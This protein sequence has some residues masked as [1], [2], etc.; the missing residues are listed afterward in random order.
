[1]ISRLTGVVIR[2][3]LNHIVL[4]VHGVGYRIAVRSSLDFTLEKTVSLNTYLAVRE[5]ALDL[6]GFMSLDE[7]HMFE[8]LIKLPKIG[9]KS[10]LQILMQA[11]IALLYKAIDDQDPVYL[12]KMSG[13]GKKTA[14]KI[15]AELKNVFTNLHLTLESSSPTSDNDTID[16]LIALGYTMKDARDAVAKIPPDI[17]NTNVRITY[18]LRTIGR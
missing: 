13:I 12:S 9:P 6:Y 4:D 17:T 15:I 18:A 3:D 10:A 5:N 14:E 16:A 8:E 11:D 2:I 7:L 1:M